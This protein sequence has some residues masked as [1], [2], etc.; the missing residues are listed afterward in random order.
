MLYDGALRFVGEAQAAAA[1]ND[2]AARGEALSRAMANVSELQNTL[3]IEEG[4]DIARE[5]DRL[6]SYINQR[7]IDVSAKRDFK[8]LTEVQKLL[9]TLREG[10]S[11]AAGASK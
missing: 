10:W 3:Q 5:L 6:Y 1:R 11:Q 7:L 8:A 2:V 9:S 4:G